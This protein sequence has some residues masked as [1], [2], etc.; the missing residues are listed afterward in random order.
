ME[1]GDLPSVCAIEQLS[2]TN[3][4]QENTFRGE[5]HN[6]PISFPHVIVHKLYKKVIG[7]ILYWHLREEVHINN[8]AI[9]PDF[10]RQG[11]GEAVL[12][13][14]LAQVQSE[15]AQY[16]VL[17]VRP[18]NVAALTLYKKLGFEFL[19]ARKNYYFMP[20]EDAVILGKR[21]KQ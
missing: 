15:G 18:S 9:H 7:Y 10:R 12:H 21:L 16:V 3:P 6:H 13:K 8:V 11:I 4:W 17:E 14:V 5:I 1:E 20:Q 19:G 2:F